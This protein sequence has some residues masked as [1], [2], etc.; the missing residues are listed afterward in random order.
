MPCG[1]LPD[2]GPRVGVSLRLIPAGRR[3]GPELSQSLQLDSVTGFW[4]G[5]S[6][7]ASVSGGEA[8]AALAGPA[9]LY[10]A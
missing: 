2:S 9:R 6:N 7:S 10:T 8:A 4:A 1:P 5:M 3:R